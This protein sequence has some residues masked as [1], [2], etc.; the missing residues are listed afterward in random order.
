VARIAS[1]RAGYA[2][3]SSRHASAPGNGAQDRGRRL[4]GCV[5]GAP[6]AVLLGQLEACRQLVDGDD[7]GAGERG[8]AGGEQSYDAL[9]E[10]AHPLSEVEVG[11]DDGGE[12]D[13]AGPGEHRGERVDAVR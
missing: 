7:P 13:R 10:H 6:G 5:D 9:T 8:E 12:C 3:D 1:C 11:V 4:G 2:P